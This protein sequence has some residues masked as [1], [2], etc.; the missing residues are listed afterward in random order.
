MQD[1]SSLYH[2]CLANK[3]SGQVPPN[4]R[5]LQFVFFSSVVLH[6]SL[7]LFTEYCPTSY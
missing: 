7:H 5:V 4:A 3:Y 1:L 6:V 2:L